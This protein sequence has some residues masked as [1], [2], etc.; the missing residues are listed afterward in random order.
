MSKGG[1]SQDDCS[2]AVAEKVKMRIIKG[3]I[4][5]VIKYEE[6]YAK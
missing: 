1:S 4:L 6:G 2:F 3:N 5:F